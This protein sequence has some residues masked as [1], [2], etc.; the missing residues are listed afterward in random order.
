MVIGLLAN[1]EWAAFRMFMPFVEPSNEQKEMRCSL[2]AL[3][4][5]RPNGSRKGGTELDDDLRLHLDTLVVENL[6]DTDLH[7]SVRVNL[8]LIDWSSSWSIVSS[9]LVLPGS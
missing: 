1:F 8:D 5:N 9:T 2:S 4:L 6:D 7:E 3:L